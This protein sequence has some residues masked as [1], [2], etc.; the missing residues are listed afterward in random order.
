MR[1]TLI[2]DDGER[3]PEIYQEIRNLHPDRI[4]AIRIGRVNPDPKR[5]KLAGQGD[6]QV[7]LRAD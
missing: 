2:G 3:D 6:L 4:D 1:F 5:P 7:L